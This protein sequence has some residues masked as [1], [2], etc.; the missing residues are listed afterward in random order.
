MSIFARDGTFLESTRMG[1]SFQPGLTTDVLPDGRLLT[2]RM[3][4]FG[5]DTQDGLH[6]RDLTWGLYDPR[7]DS[8]VS[9]GVWP[10][11]ETYVETA[12][13]A[14][15]ATI[16]PFAASSHGAVDDAGRI[17]IGDGARP[18]VR[19]YDDAGRLT[20][21]ARW[22]APTPDA[23]P[24]VATQREEAL[25]NADGPGARRFVESQYDAI[26]RGRALPAFVQ[27][28]SGWNGELWIQGFRMPGASTVRWDVLDRDGVQRAT[29]AIHADF[30][31]TQ[32]EEGFLLGTRRTDMDVEQVVRYDLRRR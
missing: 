7:T 14:V 12:G 19:T 23:D 17:H 2:S 4:G 30:S 5:I 1:S 6:R 13:T 29:V 21:I 15:R 11:F 28:R 31:P 20:R 22:S 9:Y 18:E 3:N 25:A 27:I 10:G 8:S 24:V 16:L 26:P 32:I